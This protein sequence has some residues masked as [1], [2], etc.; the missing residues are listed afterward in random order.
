MLTRSHFSP[1]CLAW[2]L[3]LSLCYL[4]LI[5]QEVQSVIRKLLIVMLT[6]GAFRQENT[7]C[8]CSSRELFPLAQ[9]VTDYT[10]LHY[11]YLGS[12]LLKC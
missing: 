7:K 12:I 8:D 3:S 11:P 4:L 9:P 10:A 2:V 6:R 5:L 1:L